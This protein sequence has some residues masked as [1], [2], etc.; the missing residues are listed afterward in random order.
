MQ[1]KVN[2]DK[3]Y[4]SQL[5]LY[6]AFKKYGIDHFYPEVV[7]C[8]PDEKLDERERYWIAYHDSYHSGYN[9]TL[10]GKATYLYDF[11]VEEV[12]KMY[13]QLK[14]ARKVAL[15]YGV[16]HSTIDKVLNDNSVPRYDART[17]HGTTVIA[18]KDGKE[19]RFGSYPECAEYFIGHGLVKSKSVTAVKSYV[20]SV[21]NG[22]KESYYGWNFRKE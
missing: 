10:G 21:A 5:K 22:R 13:S 14:S 3:E 18:E 7:E 20:S 16:D 8:I 19:M 17:I 15:V 11:D 1:H 4:F 2:Y 6:K 9:G 12:I